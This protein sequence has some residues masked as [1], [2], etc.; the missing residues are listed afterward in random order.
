M[1]NENGKA[2]SESAVVTRYLVM[3]HQANPQGTAFGGA[4]M[5]WI[6]MVAAM[7]AERHCGTEV[8]T[9]GIDSMAFKKP[10]RIG[11][12]VVLKASVNYVS[13]SSMEVGVQVTRENPCTGE[14]VIATTAHVTL[15]ALDENKQP[16]AATAVVP[17]TPDEKRRYERAKQRVQL[18]KERLRQLGG[19]SNT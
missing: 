11:D 4:I 15:V 10:V 14:K 18:R 3:P 17:E 19:D 7:A 16:T 5:S 8:V 1:T 13:R 2:P 9:A 12:Q 6:D